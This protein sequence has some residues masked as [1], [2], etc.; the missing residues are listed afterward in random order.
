MLIEEQY[1]RREIENA[2]TELGIKVV[3]KIVNIPQYEVGESL[4]PISDHADLN[5][6][7]EL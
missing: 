5:R 7:L 2:T 1:F 3:A 6:N 4:K